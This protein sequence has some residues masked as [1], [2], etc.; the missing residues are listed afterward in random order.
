MLKLSMRDRDRLVVLHQV[1]DGVLC[2]AEGARRVRLGVRHFRR[3][4]RRFEAEG[5]AAVIHRGRDR[6]SN[7]RLPATVRAAALERAREPAFHDFAPTLL[8]EHLSRDPTIGQLSADTLRAWMIA[9]GLW[10][11]R[12][13]K[14][15]HRRRRPR[16][17]AVGEL[18]QMDTSIHRWLE[19]R[20]SEEI[21]LIAMIDD[22]TS[23]LYAR[24]FPRDTGAANRQLIV[25]YVRRFGRMGAL[26]TDQAGHFRNSV[27]ARARS[28]A[29]DRETE[30]TN[31]I[32]R[33][34]LA[35]LDIE[36]ILAL[37]PQ[38]KGRVERLFETLQDRLIKELRLAGVCSMDD[39]NRFLEDIFIP[40][41]QTRFTVAAATSVDAHRELPAAL[42]LDRLFAHT[43]QRV[44]SPDFTIRYKLR[45]LQIEPAQAHSSMPRSRITVEHRLDGSLHFRWRERYLHLA[46]FVAVA[47]TA[48]PRATPPREV[49]DEKT[50]K[51]HKPAPDHPWRKRA[52]VH[53]TFLNQPDPGLF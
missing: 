14:L 28:H 13:R 36:L 51:P 23:R 35:A 4:L 53:R 5:D 34:A 33:R 44:I 49:T 26:Y 40:W 32:I 1:H 19:E 7:R 47:S 20:S 22:A 50:S 43:E 2:C 9:A 39:A 21:V 37:S 42:D 46:E 41:W 11:P 31:S 18:V 29:D 30:Q 24:F 52:P 45:C 15:R 17:A 3:L 12:E 6:P 10:K 48:S 16:R 8:A 25:D 38:A 27:G